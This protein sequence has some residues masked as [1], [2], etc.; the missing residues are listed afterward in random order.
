MK[1]LL[2]LFFVA[3]MAADINAQSPNKS[4]PY[5][6]KNVQMSGGDPITNRVRCART[7]MGGAYRWNYTTQRWS[8][9]L[10]RVTT[11]TITR[12]GL[13]VL[14]STL[15]IRPKYCCSAVPAPRRKGRTLYCE[16][17]NTIL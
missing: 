11:E 1:Y 15:I 4:V 17:T 6:W 14:Q 12:R 16:R 10:D 3:V 7:D 8:S 13:K 2:L 9:S 5:K